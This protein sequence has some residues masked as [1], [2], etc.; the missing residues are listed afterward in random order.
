M[1]GHEI[2]LKLRVK[3]RELP[4]DLTQ[5]MPPRTR[6][7]VKHFHASATTDDIEQAV[8][9]VEDLFKEFKSY[10]LVVQDIIIKECLSGPMEK[11]QAERVLKLIFDSE[12]LNDTKVGQGHQHI[13]FFR[14]LVR[15]TFDYDF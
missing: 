3:A 5:P 14:S 1:K 8:G 9:T 4:V 15:K 11:R 6:K 7:S 2:P 10:K 12:E 13:L